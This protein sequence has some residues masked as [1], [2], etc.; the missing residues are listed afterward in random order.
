MEETTDQWTSTGE[1][2][3]LFERIALRHP[4]FGSGKITFYAHPRRAVIDAVASIQVPDRDRA[5]GRLTRIVT[6]S[7]F[8]FFG[9]ACSESAV[10]RAIAFCRRLLLDLAAHEIDEMLLFDGAAIADPHAKDD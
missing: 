1:W 9:P 3:A 7:S 6:E 10:P 8:H 5:D 4:L 2:L